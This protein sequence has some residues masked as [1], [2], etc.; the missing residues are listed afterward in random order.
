MPR[1]PLD[2]AQSELA[3]RYVPLAKSI[4]KPLKLAFPS[5]ADDFESAALFGLVEAAQSFD[6]DRGV[7][8]ATFARYRIRGAL[9]DAL[10]DMVASGFH[11]NADESPCVTSMTAESEEMGR[12]LL[13][14][15]DEPVGAL[16]DGD[17]FVERCLMQLPAR[18]RAACRKIYVD[19]KSQAEAAAELGYSKSRLSYLHKESLGILSD[20]L[21]YRER[22][23][24]VKLAKSGKFLGKDAG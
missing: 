3:E 13:T 6:P 21:A 9:R 14:S 24:E 1:Q 19:G 10:R 18:H 17:E 12:M 4:A 15:P 16:F 22:V 11:G 7:K 5:S 8:F 23:E 20:A 2:A